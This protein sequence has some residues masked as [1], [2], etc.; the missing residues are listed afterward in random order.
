MFKFI[1]SISLLLLLA[2]CGGDGGGAT[3]EAELTEV[4]FV[5]DWTPNTNHTGIYAAQA[6]GYYEDH[7]LDVEIVLPGE[8]GAEQTVATGNADFGISAQENVTQAR[9]Q[10]VS[11]VSLAAIIQDNTSYLASPEEYGLETP[12]DL[13]GHPYGG[14]GSPIEEETIAS[15]MQADGADFSEV[16]ILNVG[17]VDF[18]TTVQRDVDFAWIYYGWTGIE[19]E[20]RDMPLNLID[21]TEYSD[22]LNFYT[23][24][25]I[26][27]EGLIEDDPE[28]VEAFTHATAEGYRLAM[29]DP[30]RA[31]EH[32]LEAEPDLDEELVMASQ[33]WLAD[34][35]QSEAPYWGHQ[36][37]DVWQNYMD[38]MYESDLI[39]SELDVDQAFTNEFLPD[40][41]GE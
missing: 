12:S 39:E 9:L 1:L 5:L 29:E 8:A 38:W 30:E 21:F 36:E 23:P 33:E 24:V 16:E 10:D 25:L 41:A 26:T 3:D 6:E 18:F 40:E 4:T 22:A 32:L 17:D 7:G 13:E 15:I 27:N 37:R 28:T 34:V 20:L 35:Y 11:I 19:A 31:A 14:Y 2:A